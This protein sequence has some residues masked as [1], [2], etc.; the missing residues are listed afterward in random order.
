M[1]TLTLS[2]NAECM[3]NTR[4]RVALGANAAFSALSGIVFT[5]AAP[6]VAEVILAGS[7]S[8]FGFGAV[9]LLRLLGAGLVLFAALVG[10]TAWHSRPPVPMVMTISI[11]DFGWVI[12]SALLLVLAASAF[13][14][15]GIVAVAAVA[16]VV[17]VFGVLQLGALRKRH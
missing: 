5:L 15:S 16:A 3:C 4:L 13:T 11:A 17:L 8:L 14:A 1:S 9:A 6:T 12:G 10:W 2:S 7:V